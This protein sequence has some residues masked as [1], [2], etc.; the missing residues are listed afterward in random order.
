MGLVELAGSGG[1]EA[2][3]GVMGV[4]DIEVAYLGTLGGCDAAYLACA[5]DPGVGGA[6]ADEGVVLQ[7]AGGAVGDA[8]VELL[9]GI[10][11]GVGGCVVGWRRRRSHLA[12]L[13]LSKSISMIT[14]LSISY[15]NSIIIITTSNTLNS[16]QESIGD[17]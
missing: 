13:P 4:P 10:D 15:V 11:G 1:P 7:G 8:A 3:A 17:N 16:Y 2:L 14:M 5:D 6:R 9:V 12:G